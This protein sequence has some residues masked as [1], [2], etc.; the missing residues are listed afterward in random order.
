MHPDL[1]KAIKLLDEGQDTCVLC[2]DSNI[3]R[4]S[5]RG[6]APLMGFLEESIDLTG[7]SAAD[8]V[9]GK[10]TA[11]LYCLLGVHAVYAHVMSKPA[12]QVL[13]S[14]KIKTAYGQLVSAI[15]NRAGNGQCPMEQATASIDDPHQAL[16]AIRQT[17]KRLNSK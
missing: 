11:L 6:V 9:V 4:S 1:E 3:Y 8:K 14:H 2:K 5:R 7:F 17:L 12:L 13:Q 10:A 15:Q 16:L